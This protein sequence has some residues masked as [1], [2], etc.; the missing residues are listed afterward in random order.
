MKVKDVMSSDP[1]CCTSSTSLED[2]AK[3]M[4]DW[5]CGEIPVVD[6]ADGR[7]PIGVVTDRDIVCRAVARG[8][9]PLSMKAGDCMSEPCVTVTPDMSIDACCKVLEEHHIRR[10]PVVGADGACC[11]IV[12]LADVARHARPKTAGE[13]VREV[14]EP[15]ASASTVLQ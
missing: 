12:A 13:V 11:G 14:S 6:S 9:N 4:I 7:K 8:L 5:D 3:M 10:V 2:V 1:A 15:L